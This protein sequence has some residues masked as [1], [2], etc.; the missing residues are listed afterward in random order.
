MK[1]KY[2]F[3][4]YFWFGSPEMYKIVTYKCISKSVT[5][6]IGSTNDAF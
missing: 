2:F 3:Y 1:P 6:A 4:G 5:E